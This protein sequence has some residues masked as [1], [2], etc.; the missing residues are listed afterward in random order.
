[1]LICLTFLVYRPS[2]ITARWWP[3]C[4]DRNIVNARILGDSNTY[5]RTQ[6]GANNNV[7]WINN[8]QEIG[9][10]KFAGIFK[11]QS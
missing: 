3:E 8:G 2:D 11:R 5:F 4:N 9:Q 7:V 6:R 10:S 1:M